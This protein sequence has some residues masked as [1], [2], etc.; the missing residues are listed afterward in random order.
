MSES[1]QFDLETKLELISIA[2]AMANLVT[3]GD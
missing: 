1:V 3:K 2:L